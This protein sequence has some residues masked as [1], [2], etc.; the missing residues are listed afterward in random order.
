[1]GKKQLTPE[2]KRV[3]TDLWVIALVTVGVFFI[4]A[5]TGNQFRSLATNDTISV[6]PRLILTSVIAIYGMLIVREK[7]GNAL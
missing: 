1:M 7:T 4:Y 2:Q 3:D 6:I 5:V